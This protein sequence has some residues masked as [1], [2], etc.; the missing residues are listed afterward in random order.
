MLSGTSVIEVVIFVLSVVLLALISTTLSCLMG[1]LVSLLM[2]RMRQ[3]A[4]FSLIF[5][6]ALLG[7][8][9]DS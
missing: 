1:W 7:L 3:K 8:F 9:Y 5:S 6:L 2:R 4:L